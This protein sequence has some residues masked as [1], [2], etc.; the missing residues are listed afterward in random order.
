MNVVIGKG[1]LA[2]S[3]T[4]PEIRD[5]CARAFAKLQFK[6][7]RVLVLIPDHTRHAPIP[8]FFRLIYD[9]I[10]NQVKDLDYLI[11]TGTH[12][13]MSTAQIYCHVGITAAEHQQQYANVRFFNHEHLNT[14]A[15][16][17]IGTIP[18]AEI[19]ELANNLF[20][21]DV[22]VTINKRA[23]EYDQILL[24]TPVVPHEA[25]GFAGG[26]KYFFPGI[27]GEG[28][29]RAFHWIGALVTNPLINGVKETPTRKIID[30][31]AALLKT[32]RLCLAFAVNNHKKIACLFAGEPRQAWS[33]AADYS[34]QLHIHYVEKPY[35][36]ILGIA[37]NI[38]A[39][40][41]VAG[42]VMYKL[43]PIVAD[44]GEL[45][46]YAPQVRELSS[47]H[48]EA[49]RRIGYHVRDYFLNQW[50]RFA[51]EPIL[52][53]AHSTNVRGVGTYTEGVE[54]PRIAVTLATS[55]PAEVCRSV[56]LGYRDYRTINLD[57]WRARQSDQLLVVDNAGQVL[58][59][60]R[61]RASERIP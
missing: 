33:R 21:E 40:L 16:A 58:Y 49:I 25:M 11:A 59:R 31:A 19:R 28:I 55:I 35:Q 4:E 17:T 57:D 22:E 26:N 47:V 7:K 8:L 27:A 51:H 29:I 61:D 30:R 1:S 38:Y 20:N 34:A 48:G 13:A 3:L 18:T 43:E 44:G 45:I 24:V 41:W 23:L 15:L 60:L 54:S 14:A 37:P 10:G 6:G 12:A 36:Q 39:D 52:I 2:T 53:L 50:E 9:L 5:I 42:K 46:I 56:N 32:P